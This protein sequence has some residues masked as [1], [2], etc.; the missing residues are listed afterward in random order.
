MARM[1]PEIRTRV[2]GFK[3]VKVKHTRLDEVDQQVTQAI[4]EHAGY[5]H[6]LVYGPSGVGK[7]TVIRRIA[8]RFCA[9]E[10][11]PA[12]VPVVLIE[13]RPSETGTYVR[14]D[15][16]RQVLMALKAHGVVKELLV[17]I[18][19]TPT[20]ARGSRH[21]TEWL[22]LR[23][24][25][26]HALERLHVQAVVIDEAQHRMQVAAPL[27]PTDQLDWLKSMTNRTNV[28]H[29][30][31]GTYDLCDFRN[32]HGQ[33]A[34]RGRDLHCPRYHVET[35]TERQEFVGALRYLL[36]H[37]PLPCDV[38]ALLA[39]WRWFADYS[40]G[41]VGILKDWLVQPVAAT[42]GE[43]GATLT[44][45]A[46]TRHALQP[47]QRVRLEVEAHAGEHK[48]EAGNTTSHEQLQALLGPPASLR[49][50][51]LL[52]LASHALPGPG[53]PSM[54]SPA[55]RLPDRAKRRRRV[56][57]RAPARDP[58]GSTAPA[59][60]P[61][62]C[63]FAGALDI[64]PRRLQHRETHTIECPACGAVRTVPLQGDGVR[65]PTHQPL[66]TRTTKDVTRWI[67]QDNVWTLWK[68][69]G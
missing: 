63:A 62:K 13:A 53:A 2:E 22:D 33:A 15:Y 65:F 34:R 32:L 20:P 36:E 16:Y 42:L 6:L 31:V 61:P 58:V 49:S 12:R 18:T 1:T 8:E 66:R 43:A 29:V 60:L 40:V 47:A 5:T 44:L 11:H 52:P 25:V 4:D 19:T 48:V 41:Y 17:N 64:E 7:S 67:R 27:K 30:L 24:A 51:P 10:P 45:E 37:V 3:A 28:L 26:E 69:S 21:A 56:G 54:P 23:E 9:D 35:A 39:H 14:L 46:L 55:E 50:T 68:K 57:Q 59:A 38:N